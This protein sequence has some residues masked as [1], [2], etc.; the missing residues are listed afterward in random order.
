[1]TL[2][3]Q[4]RGVEAPQVRECRGMQPWSTAKPNTSSLQMYPCD[5]CVWGVV[6]AEHR[7]RGCDRCKDDFYLQWWRAGA[8]KQ[9]SQP[10]RAAATR[11][12]QCAALNITR[13]LK[14]AS[15]AAAAGCRGWRLLV[16]PQQPHPS[17]HHS[18]LEAPAGSSRTVRAGS[19]SCHTRPAACGALGEHIQ[20]VTARRTGSSRSGGIAQR[21]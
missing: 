12:E 20:A 10:A 11:R 3:I 19:V 18:C 14:R 4:W 7:S 15:N 16:W 1:V 17:W 13:T 21:L 6:T 9:A 8:S 5:S 2:G